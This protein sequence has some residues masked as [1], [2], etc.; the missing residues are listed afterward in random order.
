[1]SLVKANG[2]GEVSTGFYNNVIDQSLRYDLGDSP[3]LSRTSDSGNRR[4]FTFAAWFKRSSFNNTNSIF[5][6][7]LNGTNFFA[8]RFRDTDDPDGGKLQIA[9]YSGSFDID[10][11]TSRVFR[12]LTS[13]YHIVVAVD[14]TQSTASDRVKLYVN[15]TQVTAFST[16]TYPSQ[17]FETRVSNGHTETVGA[18]ATTYSYIDGYLAEVNLIDGTALTPSSFGETK[19]GVWIPK[20]IS[21]LTYGTNGFRLTFSDRSSASALGTD[22]SGN[23]N[24]FSVSGLADIDQSQDSPERNFATLNPLASSTEQSF[25][26]GNL[27]TVAS[28]SGANFASSRSTI[29]VKSGKW[30]AEFRLDVVQ[31][32]TGGQD[33]GVFVGTGTK[34][35]PRDSSNQN[36]TD[37]GQTI[38]YTANASSSGRGIYVGSTLFDSGL[39]A[40]AA[41]D[42]IG[43]EMNV[44]DNEVTFYKNGTKQGN[45]RQAGV[46]T[47]DGG[48]FYFYTYVRD[49]T[50][51]TR[52]TA[53]FGQDGSFNNQRGFGTNS[54]DNGI[55]QFV[56]APS[57][58]YLALCGVNLPDTG[59]N[60][61]EDNQ[62]TDFHNV[63]TYTGSGNTTQN[64]TGVGFQPDWVW[65]KNRNTTVNHYILDSTRGLNYLSSNTTSA[66]SSSANRFNSFDSDGFQVEHTG[67]GNG[68]TNGSGQTYVAWNW[69]INGGT[70]STDTTGSQDSI[71]QT[72]QTLGMT[73]GTHEATSGTYT[74][75]H[76]LGATPEFFMFRNIDGTDNWVYWHTGMAAAGTTLQYI[77]STVANSNSGSNWLSTLNSTLI[78]ITTLQVSGT[79]GTHLFWAFR[80]IEGFS[81]FG[82]YEGNASTDGPFIYT[83]FRPSLIWIKNYDTGNTDHLIYDDQRHKSSNTGNPREFHLITNS[84]DDDQDLYDVDF[85]SNGFKIRHGDVN[86]INAGDTYLY[87]AWAHN[88]F[89]FSNAF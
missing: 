27:R 47:V 18:E 58:G 35:Y 89:K 25:S 71:I 49:Q 21:G 42:I 31:L 59:F 11:R 76:G 41:G 55:G 75:A 10:L 1:M 77:N 74:F 4:T 37:N 88:P 34:E 60:A 67:G 39:A 82:N 40:H 29:G 51:N 44:D 3:Y 12:D 36:G 52:I 83:G 54:D 80:S 32:G 64:I 17:N 68:F 43:I 84:T 85:L 87:W 8:L 26:A 22:T 20:A 15:G 65:I 53:N 72:N 61:D 5:G 24:N 38:L 46:T 57:S 73:I 81:K 56:Y 45:T 14:T 69:K 13:W 6:A 70:T 66:Q 86:N 28:S 7:T 62:P 78:G 50:A 9:N 16:E 79:S 23:S 2:A 19:N 33:N 48:F 63:V 30:Y